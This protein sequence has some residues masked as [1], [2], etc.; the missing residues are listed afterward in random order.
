MAVSRDHSLARVVHVS[1]STVYSTSTATKMNE[2]QLL[3][4]STDRPVLMHKHVMIMPAHLQ[5][6]TPLELFPLHLHKLHRMSPC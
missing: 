2:A 5:D 4:S 6:G 3:I 1:W